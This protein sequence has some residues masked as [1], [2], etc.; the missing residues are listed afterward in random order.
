MCVTCGYLSL[1]TALIAAPCTQLQKLMAAILDIRQQ[2]ITSHHGQKDEH[3][4]TIANSELQSKL[5]ACIQHH[6]EV[7][8]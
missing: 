3:V 2:H 4:H 8:E 7:M 6:Q 1:C 5:N